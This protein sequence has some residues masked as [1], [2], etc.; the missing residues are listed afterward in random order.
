MQLFQVQNCCHV[1]KTAA[2]FLSYKSYNL[3]LEILTISNLRLE[4]Q[5]RKVHKLQHRDGLDINHEI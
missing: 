3:Q 4:Q 2:L 5:D 1:V